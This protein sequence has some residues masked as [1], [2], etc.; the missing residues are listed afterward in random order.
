ML[1]I[2]FEC[3]RPFHSNQHRCYCCGA[4]SIRGRYGRLAR[5][6]RWGYGGMELT[7]EEK[8]AIA[9]LKRLARRWPK[10]LWLFSGGQG[11]I[12]VM[13]LNERGEKVTLGR[14]EGFD[15]DYVVGHID[16]PADG[17]DW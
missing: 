13:K 7:L 4:L 5:E 9:S 8:Q 17:G 16:I 10:G 12:A 15:S 6:P 2:C 11:G 1:S 3:F 14:G